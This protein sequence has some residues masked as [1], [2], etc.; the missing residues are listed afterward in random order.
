V[1][2][3]EF[4]LAFARCS[5]LSIAALKR[6]LSRCSSSSALFSTARPRTVR[7]KSLRKPRTDR[8]AV[9]LT[10]LLSKLLRDKLYGG[11]PE[12]R[13]AYARLLMEEVRVT[14]EEIRISGL[15]SALAKC[16][17]DGIA[18]PAP[19]VLSFVQEWRARQDSNL[20]PLPSEDDGS[21]S[22]SRNSSSRRPTKPYEHAQLLILMPQ[23]SGSRRLQA[24]CE[25]PT[26]HA[27]PKN[28]RL[29]RVLFGPSCGV[30]NFSRDSFLLN[31][32]MVA[33]QLVA[34]DVAGVHSRN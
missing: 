23:P 34:G 15:K 31:S 24:R 1:P 28:R 20:W 22:Q 6:S 30:D 13:Q 21:P 25:L 8:P 14:D 26:G 32:K 17:A 9:R 5:I 3:S 16:A 18:E 29:T 2:Q 33:Q 7:S 12:F 10:S 11:P 4:P 27:D 19:K